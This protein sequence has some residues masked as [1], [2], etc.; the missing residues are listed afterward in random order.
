[1]TKTIPVK[2]HS[3]TVETVTDPLAA[4]FPAAREHVSKLR[5]DIRKAQVEPLPTRVLDYAPVSEVKDTPAARLFRR[6]WRRG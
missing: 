6:L 3:R 4:S 2:A 1:M 5:A